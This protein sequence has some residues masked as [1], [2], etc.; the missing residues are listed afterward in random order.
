MSDE[1]YYLGLDPGLDGAVAVVNARGY[2]V[3]V[4][5]FPTVEIKVGKATKR[6]VAAAALVTEVELYTRFECEAIVESVA[7]RPG[8]GVA[9]VF[10]FGQTYGLIVG[11]LAGL[12]A[13][14]EFVTPRV[15]TKEMRVT[16]GKGGSRERCM[17]IWPDR[18]HIFARV[19][20]HNRADAALLAR[21]L[22]EKS[23]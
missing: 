18:A 22:W 13:P 3:D 14:T 15:W 19:K 16:E 17:Q 10:S 2:L 20:D 12:K 6:R 1:K 5:D 4:I 9:S 11:V 8:Q 23:K 21:Y 7:S